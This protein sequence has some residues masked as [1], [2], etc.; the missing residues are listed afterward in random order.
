MVDI[1]LYR[2]NRVPEAARLDAI[3]DRFL[4]KVRITRLLSEVAQRT[5]FT[6]RFTELRSGKTHPNPQAL[7]A[8]VLLY[9]WFIIARGLEVEG[10]TAASIVTIDLLVSFII[11]GLADSIS[12]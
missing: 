4:P 2:L 3:V 8:A 7:L 10:F 5:G 11:S 6:D 9:E 12:D 1:L